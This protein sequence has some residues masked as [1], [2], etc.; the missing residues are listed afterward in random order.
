M[1]RVRPGSLPFPVFADQPLECLRCGYDLRGLTR[2]ERCPE[3]GCPAATPQG[4]EA[5]LAA[6]V[7]VTEFGR[8]GRTVAMILTLG[9]W[10]L[11]TQPIVWFLLMASG[12]FWLAV[13]L[14]LATIGVSVWLIATRPRRSN[15][16][17]RLV[18]TRG[19]VGRA[20]WR[21]WRPVD[22]IEW[23]RHE[24]VQ[25]KSVSTVWQKLI[26]RRPV[27][28]G[29]APKI[30]EFG[31]RCRREHVALVKAVVEAMVLGTALPEGAREALAQEG[32]WV[33]HPGA[34][35]PADGT[36]GSE[37]RALPPTA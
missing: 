5:L 30:I 20:A 31:F 12:L 15:T 3:C 25:I 23:T 29:R 6:G 17:E 32:A 2:P 1:S 9:G 37:A 33:E 13:G 4:A 28:S 11:M 19:G 8:P 36:L 7:P 35:A 27:E 21:S 10:G 18:F 22:F 16:I 26:I 34:V 24:H 14:F